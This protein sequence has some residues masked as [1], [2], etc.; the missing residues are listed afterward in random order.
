M[1]AN[2]G[3]PGNA[4]SSSNVQT[5]PQYL[6]LEQIS[7]GNQKCMRS[8]ELR[9]ALGFPLSSA[10]EDHMFRLS[11]FK[12]SAPVAI[13]D[14][15]N[16]KEDV[17]NSSL[18]ARERSNFFRNSI[19]KLDNY[20]EV[21]GSKKRQRSPLS[22]ERP[23]GASILKTAGQPSR[24][25]ID[26]S[27]QKL[28]DWAKC[29]GT[30]KRL[31]SATEVD[32]KSG[33]LSRDLSSNVKDANITKPVGGASVQPEERTLRLSAVGEGWDKNMRRKRSIGIVV[34]NTTDND[35][36]RTMQTKLNSDTKLASCDTSAVR[37]S[38][39]SNAKQDT[40]SGSTGTNSKGKLPRAPRTA[41]L[42]VV[43]SADV[44]ASSE[45][46]E[47]WQQHPSPNKVI[48]LSLVQN[49]HHA[50]KSSRMLGQWGGQRQQKSARSRRINVVSP[51]TNQ[52]E[53]QTLSLNS[54]PPAV[55]VRS[56]LDGNSVSFDSADVHNID[57]THTKIKFENTPSPGR[58][59]EVE[60]IL[61]SEQIVEEK[62]KGNSEVTVRGKGKVG[63]F[64]LPT[65]R[66]KN[67]LNENGV[68]GIRKQG[69][70]V[71]GLSLSGVS[72][73]KSDNMSTIKRIQSTRHS[74]EKNRG[75]SGRPPLKKMSDGRANRNLESGDDFDE[76]LAA[77]ASARKASGLA[78]SGR[79]WK[80]MEPV[81]CSVSPQDVRHLKQQL[82]SAEELEDCQSLVSSVEN[83]VLGVP[84]HKERDDVPS[85]RKGSN[86]DQ[87]VDKNEA[88]P[89]GL[90]R[91]RNMDN[92][93]SLYQRVLCALIEDDEN[94]GFCN[95]YEGAT[96]VSVQC[97]SDDSHCGSCNYTETETRDRDRFE[98]EAE[99][100]VDFQISKRYS[101]DRISCNKSVTSNTTWNTSMS[102]SLYSSGRW[103]GDDCLSYSDAEFIGGSIQNDAGGPQ[104]ET[105][106]GACFDSQYELMCVDDKLVM[107]LQSIGLYPDELPDLAEGEVLDQD[108]T[109]LKEGLFDQ[110]GKKK[111]K[112]GKIDSALQDDNQRN[113]RFMEQVAMEQLI[114][115]AYKRRM[116]Y[117]RNNASKT[118]IRK[119]SKQVAMGFIERTLIRCRAFEVSGQ[120]SFSEPAFQN[121]LF[122]TP[123]ITD[124]G[125]N[126]V[127]SAYVGSGSPKHLNTSKTDSAP[128]SLPDSCFVDFSGSCID[129]A[130]AA[131]K[132][133][134]NCFPKLESSSHKS[135]QRE[136]VLDDVGRAAF[137]VATTHGGSLI[138][139]AKGKSTESHRDNKKGAVMTD[140]VRQN[141]S[142]GGFKSE[143]K[144]KAKTKQKA[145]ATRLLSSS[146]QQQV[147]G[148]ERDGD[149]WLPSSFND[150]KDTFINSEEAIDFDS[151]AQNDNGAPDDLN[152]WFKD[153]PDGDF[154][155]CLDI[156]MDDLSMVL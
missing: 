129:S 154:T 40:S 113:K 87:V 69:R 39:R 26:Q 25:P 15:R 41:T 99:S 126:K 2:G 21:I 8:G 85:G 16:Y 30:N 141:Q 66:N 42:V 19:S 49:N 59:S 58:L 73:V 80:K 81:F 84:I 83:N 61:G 90:T 31:R 11:N 17:L 27:A 131:G 9:R 133:S 50:P 1:G 23:G 115:M 77:A 36:K 64:V 97:A 28:E 140:S 5:L 143:E 147:P 103:L 74:S 132:L 124:A 32:G 68:D 43:N 138:G 72:E 119:V 108:I 62:E 152:D 102:D 65:K 48:S 51:V 67:F 4:I 127:N 112:L 57:F 70:T 71:R 94:D 33:S 146:I 149:V 111:I 148:N 145:S 117:R 47:G 88:V 56:P 53:C 109:E 55:A 114:Q 46:C 86:S 137:D 142:V 10:S 29:S 105:A 79:L 91:E 121:V 123:Q 20:M 136:L 135:S 82:S 22:N 130:Q 155:G 37:L 7:L 89:V 156:P 44:Q 118:I 75:K 150:S 63:A 24:Y 45:S 128:Q 76:L 13:A 106:S 107:E 122:A 110:I 3:I 18:K 100:I 93:T 78:C 134:E 139:G 153:L 34:S 54:G 14:L 101:G 125:N 151:I 104:R 95:G 52:D 144:P 12:P 38:S 116:A 6:S 60:E 98:S 120:S 92:F 96:A 35:P